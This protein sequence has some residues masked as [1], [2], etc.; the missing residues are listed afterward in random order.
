[1]GTQ[2]EIANQIRDRGADYVLALKAN[3]GTLH[4]DV[5]AYFEEGAR[6]DYRGM[7]VSYA[8][9][10]DLGHGRKEVRRLWRSTDVAWPAQAERWSGLGSIAMLESERHT[11]A[12][13][14]RE[15]RYYISSLD[16]EAEALLAAVRSHW[17]IENEL[18]WVLDMVF[19]ED[20]SR[21]RRDHGGENMA[22]LRHIALNLL[23]QDET[24]RLS[25]RMKRKRAGWDDAF[26]A[27]VVGI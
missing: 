26:L 15:R 18:H 20:E 25:L 9:T 10:T 23:R 22:V 16:A 21:I 14:A 13:I 3:Q 1:M 12:G 27:E 4:R 6:R 5:C 7:A 17:G 19:R 24:K 2:T 8:E 11:E